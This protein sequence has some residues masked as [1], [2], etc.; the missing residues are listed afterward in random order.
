MMIKISCTDRVV[1]KY[2]LFHIACMFVHSSTVSD[3]TE[4]FILPTLL[5]CKVRVKVNS[6]TAITTVVCNTMLYATECIQQGKETKAVRDNFRKV[7]MHRMLSKG[8]VTKSICG[9]SSHK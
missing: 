6:T 2:T 7:I 1:L 5:D 4:M 9:L 8:G 3:V